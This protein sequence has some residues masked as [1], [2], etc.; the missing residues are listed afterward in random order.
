MKAN[1]LRRI[2]VTLVA[3]CIAIGTASGV[4]Q[5]SPAHTLVQHSVRHIAG[6]GP[7]VPPGIDCIT[8]YPSW[9]T[10]QPLEISVPV[11]AVNPCGVSLY[12]ATL[13]VTVTQTCAGLPS[14]NAGSAIL[15]NPFNPGSP[16]NVTI[17]VIGMCE[18]CTNPPG[19]PPFTMSLTLHAKGTE[20]SGAVDT[21]VLPS[22]TYS[23]GL[24]NAPSYDICP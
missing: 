18:I 21:E 14:Y 13:S 4:V 8:L 7:D 9:I 22:P 23:H 24:R 17:N 10:Q 6:S 19:Y 1:L 2:T 15:G 11:Q 5:A 16:V 3:V 20:S 12:K